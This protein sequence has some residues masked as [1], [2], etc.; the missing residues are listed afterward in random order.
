MATFVFD[1]ETFP[2]G[3]LFMAQELRT[4][5]RFKLWRHEPGA[6]TRLKQFAVNP[7]HEFIGFNSAYFDDV[8]VNAWLS[9]KD[10]AHIK[11]LANQ[12]IDHRVAPWA[13]TKAL[14][15]R[16]FRSIDLMAAAPPFVGLKALGA[17]MNMPRLQDLPLPHDATLTAEDF[18]TV[19]NYCANDV[20]TTVALATAL[21]DQLML[22]VRMS[23]DYGMDLRS[24]SDAQLAERSLMHALGLERGVANIVPSSVR[25]TPP[26]Y[27]SFC[28]PALQALLRR[29][30]THP[31]AINETGHPV[32]PDFLAEEIY[33]TRTGRYQ[34]GVGG[35]HSVHDKRVCHVATAGVQIV[36][37]DAQ[38]FY[39]SLLILNNFVPAGLGQRFTD[40]LKNIYERRL[41]AKKAGDKNTDASLKVAINSVFGQLGNRYSVLYS[42]DLLLAV[43]LTGQ[44][45]LL[46]LVERLEA[47]G[48][49]CLS[50]N[51][52]GVAIRVTDEQMPA[53]Q[54]AVEEFSALSRLV[55]EFTSYSV[56]ALK[57]VNNYFAVKTN[58][59]VKSKGIYAEPGLRKNPAAPVCARAVGEWLARGTPF[60]KTLNE[61]RF[62]DFLSARNVTG[63]GE[64]NGVPLGKVVRWYMSN[65]AT[66]EPLRYVSN[67][68]KVPKTDGAR[69]CMELPLV[70]PADLDRRW[71]WAECVIIA[72]SVGCARLLSKE[73]IR[74]AFAVRNKKLPKELV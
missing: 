46:M 24:K 57:D 18:Q 58:K 33:T 34:L 5:D 38:S 26:A 36:D 19:E 4:G 6:V 64:Q 13:L 2:N 56:L 9:S 63:G 43:T 15:F 62:E 74:L 47:C 50:A 16:H 66:L 28:T 60:T 17:R 55:F 61:A 32:N 23:R 53:V 21:E 37:V 59:Q 72:C 27:L 39:P 14:S 29:V 70:K 65:D 7:Q 35:V 12:L 48:A 54:R 52:D 68:N 69:A 10:E 51:T 11:G 49:E 1:T 25:Y 31:F 73:H 20:E 30:A 71:Y 3:T 45:T 40:E 44:L 67:G 22:R 8:V 41:S 42:P